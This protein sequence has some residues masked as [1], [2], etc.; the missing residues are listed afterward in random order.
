MA[1]SNAETLLE[2]GFAEAEKTLNDPDEMERF[3]QRLEEKLKIV[4]VAGGVLSNIPVFIS[5]IRSY[6]NKEYSDIPLGTIIAIISA[7]LYFLSPLDAIPDGIPVFGYAD[8]AAVIIACLNL[9]QSDVDEYKAW[10]GS[11]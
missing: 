9:V 7:L 4:P 3:L 6:I 5:M 1:E 8:D 10:R 11:K 2:S